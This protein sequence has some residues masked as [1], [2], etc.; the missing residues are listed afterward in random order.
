[1]TRQQQNARINV[2]D[3]EWLT[4]R[5]RAMH[6]GRSVAEYLGSLVRAELG[7]ER[8]TRPPRSEPLP[9][10]GPSSP[11]RR[12]RLADREVLAG[13]PY[14]PDRRHDRPSLGEEGTA[15]QL[16]KSFDRGISDCRCTGVISIRDPFR[17]PRVQRR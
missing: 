2:T 16:G 7:E 10:G 14:R 5:T 6:E 9:S 13:L 12:T 11:R 15:G 3:G 17:D 4:F 8:T 1:M